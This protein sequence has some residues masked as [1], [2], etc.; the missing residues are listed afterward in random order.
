LQGELLAIQ[1]RVQKTILFVTHDVEEALRLADRLVV[2]RAGKIVQFDTPLR[3]LTQPA[4]AGVS[5]LLGADDVLR[6][7]SLLRTDALPLG[8]T[9]QEA[10]PIDAATRMREALGLLLAS[11]ASALTVMH[12]GQALGSFG[13][14]QL[15]AAVAQQAA[16]ATVA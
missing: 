5:Q 10:P 14:E 13:L 8:P 2:M 6:K 9:L 11:G 15:R 16:P 4:D 7:L 12:E 1:Q 3:V